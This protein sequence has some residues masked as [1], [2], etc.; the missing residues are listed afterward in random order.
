MTATANPTIGRFGRVQ[1]EMLECVY[2]HRLLSTAQLHA[3]YRDGLSLRR[4]Q[5]SLAAMERVGWLESVREPGGMKLWFVTGA[6]AEAVETVTNRAESR[7]TLIP[8]EQAAGPLQQHTLAVNEVGVAFVR[9]ACEQGDEFGPLAWRNEIAHPLG[10]TTGRRARSAAV[11]ADA[12]LTY[13]QEQGDSGYTHLRFLE[14]DRATM[15]TETLVAKL[16]RYLDLHEY[17]APPSMHRGSKRFTGSP[18]WQERYSHFP[19]VM[20][21]LANGSRTRLERRRWLTCGRWKRLYA[22]RARYVDLYVCLLEDLIEQGPFAPIFMSD[23]ADGLVNWLGDA[24][25]EPDGPK[26]EPPADT[27]DE[28]EPPEDLEPESTEP[29]DYDD[30]DWEASAFGDDHDDAQPDGRDP[31]ADDGGLMASL[32]MDEARLREPW[33]RG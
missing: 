20:V 28:P 14:L 19:A 26:H 18:Q 33:E 3:L 5:R 4:T 32:R 11:I 7:R 22:E 13:E 9:A 15:A 25:P 29:D 16:G 1:V 17:V 2:Q 30:A 10:A 27:E 23:L 21:V 31:T 6:G 12:V 8:C 24:P